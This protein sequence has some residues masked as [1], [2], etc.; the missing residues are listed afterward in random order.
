MNEQVL[1]IPTKSGDI[2][3]HDDDVTDGRHGSSR[4]NAHK[5]GAY[6]RNIVPP[7]AEAKDFDADWAELCDELMPEGPSETRIVAQIAQ[8][9]YVRS[10]LVKQFAQSN[11]LRD[12]DELPPTDPG[13]AQVTNHEVEQGLKKLKD[14]VGVLGMNFPTFRECVENKNQ[15]ST[16]QQRMLTTI[17]RLAF[18]PA[19]P[20]QG[21]SNAAFETIN[22]FIKALAAIDARTDKAMQRLIAYKEYK[23]QYCSKG[24]FAN[25]VPADVIT[26]SK[27]R[28]VADRNRQEPEI[29]THTDTASDPGDA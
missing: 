24:S 29:R 8:L 14:L 20:L 11:I 1:M 13:L 22:R 28:N 27:H 26:Q 23:R 21:D 3:N 10:T 5:H 2:P 17:Y 25:Q 12:V 9:Q 18:P 6:A 4:G 16:D 15:L 7:D 19:A